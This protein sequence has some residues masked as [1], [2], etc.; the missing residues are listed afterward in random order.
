M[1]M[2]TVLRRNFDSTRWR[3]GFAEALI[4]L[5]PGMNPDAADELSD[6]E[7]AG[8]RDID[9]STAASRWLATHVPPVESVEESLDRA[10]QKIG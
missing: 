4:R 2:V 5:V 3:Q 10:D 8:C 9:P 6:S 7:Y 1:S